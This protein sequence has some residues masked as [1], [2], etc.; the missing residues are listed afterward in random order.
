MA[1]G[2]NTYLESDGKSVRVQITSTVAKNQ[3]AYVDGWLGIA[4]NDGVDEDYIT[5]SI[6]H[7][8]YQF[9]VPTA[10]AVAN[11]DVVW[12]DITDLTGNLPD[13]TAYYKTADT[14]R[15]RLF[16][17]TSAQDADDVVTGILLAGEH[18]S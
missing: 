2:D 6:D 15:I 1:A 18:A 14:N 4:N 10:L 8:E 9:T 17:A 12:I 11:G 3:V 5:L 16:K 7:R 13:S